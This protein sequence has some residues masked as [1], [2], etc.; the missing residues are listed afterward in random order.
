MD[1]RRKAMLELALACFILAMI[2]M[3]WGA[4]INWG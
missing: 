1:K 4:A 2:L 3:A